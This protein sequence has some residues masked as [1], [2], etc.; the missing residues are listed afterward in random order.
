MVLGHQP[1]VSLWSMP[2]RPRQPTVY[3]EA[4]L[5]KYTVWSMELAQ[6]LLFSMRNIPSMPIPAFLVFSTFSGAQGYKGRVCYQLQRRDHAECRR[7]CD[8]GKHGVH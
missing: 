5:Y 4:M 7:G 6:I 1:R 3:T 8:K 2:V